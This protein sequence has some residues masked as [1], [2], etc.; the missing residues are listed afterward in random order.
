M[1]AGDRLGNMCANSHAPQGMAQGEEEEAPQVLSSAPF[2]RPDAI[3]ANSG[4]LCVPGLKKK[5]Q[6]SGNAAAPV[7]DS[8]PH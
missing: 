2:L 6:E 8:A 5:I 3:N 7:G 4:T 1:H